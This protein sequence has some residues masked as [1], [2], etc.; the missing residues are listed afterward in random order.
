MM[1]LL[2]GLFSTDLLANDMS[3]VTLVMDILKTNRRKTFN[4]VLPGDLAAIPSEGRRERSPPV[5]SV[6]Q[7]VEQRL[8]HHVCHLER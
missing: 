1:A 7:E 8:L 2:L 5:K 4:K 3:A 6:L